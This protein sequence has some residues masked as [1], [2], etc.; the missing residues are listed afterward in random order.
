ML[1]VSTLSC[2]LKDGGGSSP[3]RH[4]EDFAT[5]LLVPLCVQEEILYQY[6]VSAASSQLKG[7][8]GIFLTLCDML[9]NVTGG[10]ILRWDDGY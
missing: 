1:L 4:D 7:V 9:E 8:R 2:Q 10:Q 3:T 6:P 5:K